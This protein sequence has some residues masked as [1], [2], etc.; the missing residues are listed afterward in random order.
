[1]A[2]IFRLTTPLT[3]EFKGGFYLRVELV[4]QCRHNF[5]V[6]GLVLFFD[7]LLY[8]RLCVTGKVYIAGTKISLQAIFVFFGPDFNQKWQWKPKN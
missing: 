7:M 2:F 6:F 8:L 5:T 3:Q 4:M 1:M